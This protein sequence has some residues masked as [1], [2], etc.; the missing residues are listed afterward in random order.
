MEQYHEPGLVNIGG[1][2]YKSILDLAKLV[3]KLIGYE[4]EIILDTIMP[5]ST[6]RKLMY[7]SKLHSPGWK[8]FIT[9]DKGIRNVYN[10]VKDR[11]WD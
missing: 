8:T 3:Q 7:V 5:Y 1:V 9:L 6:P 10:E 2:D 4:K 11:S